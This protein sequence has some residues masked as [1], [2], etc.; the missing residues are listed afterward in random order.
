ML[1]PDVRKI[2]NE[3]KA[4]TL[5]NELPLV[6]STITT[7]FWGNN[8][9]HIEQESSSREQQVLCRCVPGTGLGLGF[10]SARYSQYMT[11]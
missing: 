5:S 2:S 1:C 9:F 8:L 4:A 7:A 3:A 6:P 10:C 11:S